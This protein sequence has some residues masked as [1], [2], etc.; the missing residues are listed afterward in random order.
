MH[1]HSVAR[2]VVAQVLDAMDARGVDAVDTVKVKIGRL[3]GITAGGLEF[4]WEVERQGSGLADADL[5]IEDQP[6]VVWCPEGEHAVTLDDIRFRC[7]VHGCATG[8]VLS[9]DSLELVSFTPAAERTG[10]D[11]EAAT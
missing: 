7:D 9:G 6:V 2:A 10:D 8:E 4:G 3:A 11:A 1:E 5:V